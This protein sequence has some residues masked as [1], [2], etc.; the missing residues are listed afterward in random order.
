MIQNSNKIG[1]L[2]F[3]AGEVNSIEL[4]C[5]LSTCVNIRL[6]GASSFDRHGGYVFK[7]YTS[8]LPVI[9]DARFIDALNELIAIKQIDVIFPTHDTVAE[10][11]AEHQAEIHAKVISA[12]AETSEICRDKKKTFDLFSDCSFCPTIYT[13]PNCFPIFAKPRRGQGA[14]GAYKISDLSE[15][16]SDVNWDDMVICEYLPGEEYTVDCIT[17]KHGAL[18]GVFPRS[19][20][21]VLAGITVGG[22][23]ESLTEEIHYIAETLNSRL[24]FLGLWYFQIKKAQDGQFKLMEIST[25]CAGTMCLSRARGVNPALLSVYIAMGKDVSV[26]SN[27]YNVTVDRTFISRYKIDYDYDH[28]YLDL[29]DT[30]LMNGKVCLETVRFLYQ[31]FNKSIPVTLLTRHDSDHNDTTEEYLRKCCISKDLFDEIIVIGPDQKKVDYI[32]AQSPIFIDNAFSERKLVHDS[33]NIP[34][35]DVDCIEVL[36]DWRT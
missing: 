4:H 8:D 36:L 14:V 31:C 6:Y 19:R 22:S 30:L 21:R 5:A 20:K 24:K 28:V 27:Q 33:L 35:F 26:F 32:K 13:S 18:C 29:D 1:V 23:T 10:Y 3:P 9:T 25:R 2:V 7:D 12:D 17:D 34:V 11:M 15:V 16:P